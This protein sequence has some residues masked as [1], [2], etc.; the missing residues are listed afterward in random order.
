MPKQSYF[1]GWGFSD[2]IPVTISA[3]PRKIEILKLELAKSFP[4]NQV[5]E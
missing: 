2:R 1:E 3:T 5:D 4:D